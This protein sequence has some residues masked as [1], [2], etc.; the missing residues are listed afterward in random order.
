MRKLTYRQRSSLQQPTMSGERVSLLDKY[1]PTLDMDPFG[2]SAKYD[3]F[4]PFDPFDH[5]SMYPT[6]SGHSS[7]TL[8]EGINSNSWLSNSQLTP[9]SSTRNLQHTSSISSLGSAGPAS[10]YTAS[11]SNPYVVG[12][13]YQDFQSQVSFLSPQYSNFYQS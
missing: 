3:P 5:F 1:V 7:Q 4:D 6:G 13:L 9:S 2:L 11:S 10:P 12:D 8:S